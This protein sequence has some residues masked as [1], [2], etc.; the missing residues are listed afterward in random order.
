MVLSGSPLAG[1][2]SPC[3]IWLDTQALPMFLQAE[4]VIEDNAVQMV[5]V[6]WQV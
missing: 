1:G 6:V 3:V 5:E 4:M 2:H